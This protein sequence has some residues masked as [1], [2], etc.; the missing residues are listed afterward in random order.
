[1]IQLHISL[2]HDE[3]ICES[4]KTSPNS[5]E[6]HH[7][8]NANYAVNVIQWHIS[9]LHDQQICESDETFFRRAIT[10]PH[11]SVSQYIT[12]IHL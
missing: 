2:L 9:L 8:P 4:D 3:Q 11:V 1:M 10:T 7:G 5:P 6:D 12:H